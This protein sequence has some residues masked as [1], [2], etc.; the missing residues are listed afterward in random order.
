MVVLIP[1]FLLTRLS[2]VDS[3]WPAEAWALIAQAFALL[4]VVVGVLL[5]A[6]TIRLFGSVGRGTLAPWDPTKQLVVVGPYRYVRN[7]MISS[8]LVMQL[9]IATFFG[10]WVALAWFAF[11]VCLNA[12]YLILAEEPQLRRKFGESYRIYCEQVPRWIPRTTPWEPPRSGGEE[13]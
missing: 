10:S 3:R 7:P 2:D 13:G 9:A 11:F 6:W 4:L 8:V 12:T 1:Y 5:F